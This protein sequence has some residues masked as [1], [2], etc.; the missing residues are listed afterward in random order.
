VGPATAEVVRTILETRPHPEMGYRACL[1]IMRLGKT[2]SPQRLEAASVRALR[3]RACSYTSIR[4][5]LK[6]SLDHQNTI[7]RD[8]CRPG[9]QHDNLRGS[10]Y[11][12]SA[13]STLDFEAREGRPVC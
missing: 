2:Y 4:S 9:P 13:A 5:I 8:L 6:R 10:G 3:L 11:Y 7:D 1:G 12:E